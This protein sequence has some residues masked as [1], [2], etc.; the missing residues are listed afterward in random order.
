MDLPSLICD[1]CPTSQLFNDSI[2]TVKYTHSNSAVETPSGKDQKYEN[3]PV[4][5]WVLPAKLRPHIATF[6]KFARTIDDIADTNSLS[7][8]EKIRRLSMF[9]A[10][11]TGKI[12]GHP[13]YE[14][15]DAMRLSLR[16][17]QISIQH[18]L[19]LIT[20]FKR[21]ATKLRYS[22]WP[23]LINYC[24]YSA[25]PVGR[26]L[27][28]L[29]G[30]GETDYPPSDALCSALQI[31]NHLQDCKGDFETMNRVY[32]PLEILQKHNVAINDLSAD[33]SSKG[34]RN[35][36]KEILHKTEILINE[37]NPLIRNLKSRRLAMEALSIINIAKCLSSELTVR[38]PLAER[39]RLSK[40]QYARS[41]MAGVLAAVTTQRRAK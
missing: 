9:E 6:Y 17:T 33:A 35:V 18:C 14:R 7:A 15:G 27:I 5:S 41:C 4:G 29:H 23:S 39:V 38:D 13:G 36:K 19:D 37:A 3:F 24:R 16:E 25:A 32:L 1:A 20:A 22:D 26:Y 30:G 8:E 34:L 31:L 21:D 40:W 28:D 11:L 2:R 10:T 12:F